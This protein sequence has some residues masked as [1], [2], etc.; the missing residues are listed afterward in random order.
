VY[1]ARVLGTP[2]AHD[3]SRLTKGVSIDGRR[4][5]PSDVVALGPGHLR[6][7]V[8]EGRNR[9][10][11]KMCEAIGHPVDE[12]RRIAIGPIRDAKLRPGHWRELTDQEVER[13]RRAASTQASST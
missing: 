2:D 9:Q 10:V 11:R 1:E 8:R 6:I 4:T 13:L 12:L 7:T 5:G 3:I